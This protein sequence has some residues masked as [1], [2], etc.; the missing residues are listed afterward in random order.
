MERQVRKSAAAMVLA[1]RRGEIFDAVVTGASKKGTWV[2][3]RRPMAEGRLERG[4]EGV[5]VGDRLRV[6]LVH[7]DVSKGFIDF[8]K[9]EGEDTRLSA[10]ATWSVMRRA[11]NEYN[12]YVSSRMNGLI[13]AEGQ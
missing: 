13:V 7:T 4:A 5:E 9:S 6:R 10:I 3:L 8:E 2:R 1:S 11:H 12:I